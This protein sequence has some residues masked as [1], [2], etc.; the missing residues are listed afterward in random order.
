[1]SSLSIFCRD[2]AELT[3]P[4]MRCS[5]ANCEAV[6]DS[7]LTFIVRS[8]MHDGCHIE[9]RPRNVTNPRLAWI[10]AES[11]RLGQ[12]TFLSAGGSPA[13][14]LFQRASG[15]CPHWPL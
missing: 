12:P 11:M 5:S 10:F 6:S 8:S 7:A 13:T 3:I 1:M 2:I 15:G 14:F 4:L 9:Q